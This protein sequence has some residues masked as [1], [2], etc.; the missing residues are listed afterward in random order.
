M[1]GKGY[2]QGKV[3]FLRLVCINSIY[4]GHFRIAHALT[5]ARN[6]EKKKEKSYNWKSFVSRLLYVTVDRMLHNIN[7]YSHPGMHCMTQVCSNVTAT[8]LVQHVYA[9][10]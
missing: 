2:T 9:P 10:R 6:F 3:L 5:H 7:Q 8:P 4:L 1:H